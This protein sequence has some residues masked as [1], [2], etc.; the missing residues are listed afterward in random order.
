MTK[1]LTQGNPFK[2]ILGFALPML[3]G[4]LFQQLY[5]MADTIIVG[6]YLGKDALAAVGSTG[7]VH[8]LIIGFAMGI[9]SG[10]AIPIAHRFG[11]R[12]EVGLRKTVANSTILSVIIAFAMAVITVILCRPILELMQTPSNIIDDAYKYIVI[13]FAGIP[14]TFLYNMTSGIIRS[15]GDSKTPVYFLLLSSVLNVVLDLFFIINVGMGVEGAAIATVIAQLAS[16]LACLFYMK[17]KYEILHIRKEE[18]KL[19]G[20]IVGNL[21]G[22][23]IPMG[24]QYSI[25]AIGSVILQTA[26]NGLG[27]DAVAAFTAGSKLG[28]FLVCP[29]DALGSTMATYAGQNVGAKK[30]ERL[31]PGLLSAFGMGVMYSFLALA[32]ILAAGPKMLLLF[33]NAGELALIE[34]AQIYLIYNAVAYILL[35]IVNV[36][37]FTIQGMGFSILAIWAGV[38]EM[39]ARILGAWILVPM[40]AYRGACMGNAVAWIMADVFLIPAYIYARKKLG[41]NMKRLEEQIARE[42]ANSIQA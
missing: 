20:Q 29:F 34:N 19:E 7:S 38:F 12:D 42:R 23:G 22:M 10:F 9:C 27:S 3:V 37:R 31:T 30:L 6:Q 32:L 14:T 16:G 15:I 41:Q 39:A 28:M 24:L 2:L 4:M 35:V 26:L 18:W 1:D 33:L 17:K 5:S 25:T 8:F 36:F 21:C 13:I 40:F 11:A